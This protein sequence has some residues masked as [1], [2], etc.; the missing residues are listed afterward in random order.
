MKLIRLLSTKYLSGEPILVYPELVGITPDGFPKAIN[1]LKK[2]ADGNLFQKRFFM[3]L[4][5]TSRTLSFRTKPDYSPITNPF[6]GTVTEIDQV[7]VSRFV[8]DFKLGNNLKTPFDPENYYV[9]L[10]AGPLGPA[11]LTS[12][13]HFMLY[14]GLHLQHLSVIGGSYVGNYIIKIRNIAKD[15]LPKPINLGNRKL[16]LVYDP[17]AKTRIIAIA[18]YFTQVILNP[19][20]ERCFDLLRRIPQDRTFTQDPYIDKKPGHKFHSL[21]LSSA[22]DRFPLSVQRQ[23]VSEMIDANFGYSWCRLIVAEAFKSP[24]GELLKYSVGQPMGLRSSWAVF[25]LSHHMIVQ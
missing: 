24:E 3:T 6:K 16:A 12:M 17:E 20:S 19:F 7:F 4:M 21:D 11:L 5:V 1:F 14:T 10:K 8:K 13:Q 18:D 2:Y 23:L 9:T 22:T 15:Y 25:T